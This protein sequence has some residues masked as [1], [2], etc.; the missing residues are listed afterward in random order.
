MRLH[1]LQN[2]GNSAM[3]CF[4]TA[5]EGE[6]INPETYPLFPRQRRAGKP[7]A[8]VQS[9]VLAHILVDGWENFLI[10]NI[11]IY[12]MESKLF[13]PGFNTKASGEEDN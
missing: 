10:L 13:K 4:T 1:L 11:L 5:C 3:C 9:A 2:K 6:W 12:L 7:N 8:D